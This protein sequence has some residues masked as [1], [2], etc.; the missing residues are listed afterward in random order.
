M[1][2][3][4][5]A[6]CLSPTTQLPPLL[7]CPSLFFSGA[8]RERVSNDAAGGSD[9]IGAVPDQHMQADC[10]AAK[11]PTAGKLLSPGRGQDICSSQTKHMIQFVRVAGHTKATASKRRTLKGYHAYNFL[12]HLS[13]TMTK[14]LPRFPSVG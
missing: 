3:K 12:K 10:I 14:M 11:I 6:P 13:L 7:P 8:A 1:C 9:S 2:C 5:H 4:I